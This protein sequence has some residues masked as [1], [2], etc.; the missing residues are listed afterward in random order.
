M[1]PALVSA[2]CELLVPV[3]MFEFECYYFG[4]SVSCKLPFISWLANWAILHLVMLMNF[5]HDALCNRMFLGR[6]AASDCFKFIVKS[7]VTFMLSGSWTYWNDAEK[8]Q[9]AYWES[10]LRI[11]SYV[12]LL[13]FRE[14]CDQNPLRWFRKQIC[15]VHSPNTGC[16][17][18]ERL[19]V[20]LKQLKI[21]TIL[22][23]LLLGVVAEKKKM[24]WRNWR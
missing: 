24:D 15:V 21:M 2:I 1:F 9:N 18:S 11:K 5:L 19:S 4:V 16:K 3:L 10:S 7:H 17:M 20:L 22:I 23:F 8:N 6:V 13:I 12:S 14:I